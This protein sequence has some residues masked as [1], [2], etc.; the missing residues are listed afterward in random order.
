MQSCSFIDDEVVEDYSF[1]AE[2][3]F[4][5]PN[6]P[7]IENSDSNIYFADIEQPVLRT[8]SKYSNIFPW[9]NKLSRNAAL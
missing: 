4:H 2:S 1:D 5:K 3:N 7:K 8:V 9:L 6:S